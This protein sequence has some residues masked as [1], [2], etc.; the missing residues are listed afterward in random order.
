[1]ITGFPDPYCIIQVGSIERKTKAKTKTLNPEWNETITLYVGG[2]REGGREEGGWREGRMEGGWGK[3][4]GE[5]GGGMEGRM[6]GEWREDG[7]RT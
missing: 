7:G 2:R 6:E 4:G 5:D 1:V 3:D